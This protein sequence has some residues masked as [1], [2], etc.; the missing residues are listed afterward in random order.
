[1]LNI[2]R[3]K[4]PLGGGGR[5]PKIGRDTF[6][7]LGIYYPSK[8]TAEE[9]LK[10]KTKVHPASYG[11]YM[12]QAMLD[13]IDIGSIIISSNDGKPH[14]QIETDEKGL[15]REVAPPD[16]TGLPILM[17][18]C[19]Q[20]NNY[21][22]GWLTS[23]EPEGVK[24]AF[25]IME[26]RK[27]SL[28]FS[29]DVSVQTDPKTGESKISITPKHIAVLGQE[30]MPPGREG[31]DI[32][33]IVPVFP[34]HNRHMNRVRALVAQAQTQNSYPGSVDP[35]GNIVGGQHHI[36]NNSKNTQRIMT[37]LNQ[38]INMNMGGNP[39]G[40]NQH[41]ANQQQQQQPQ[42]QAASQPP[43][44][45]YGFTVSASQDLFNNLVGMIP[46][47]VSA[48]N[49]DSASCQPTMAPDSSSSSGGDVPANQ[50]ESSSSSSPPSPPEVAT[51][52]PQKPSEAAEIMELTY[53]KMMESSSIVEGSP[54]GLVDAVQEALTGL[55][56]KEL[57]ANPEVMAAL[58]KRHQKHKTASPGTQPEPGPEQEVAEKIDPISNPEEFTIATLGGL[59]N[60]N[61]SDNLPPQLQGIDIQT[62]L[63]FE[64]WDR[65][66]AESKASEAALPPPFD[67]TPPIGFR[68]TSGQSLS[69]GT[70]TGTET[71][72]EVVAPQKE[73]PKTN[74]GYQIPA[75]TN[76]HPPLSSPTIHNL[77][78]PSVD[79]PFVFNLPLLR[80]TPAVT[81]PTTATNTNTNNNSQELED[82][83][84]S[85]PP[86]AGPIPTGGPVAA[87]PPAAAAN[88]PQQ[89]A[90]PPASAPQQQQPPAQGQQAP[91]TGGQQQQQPPTPDAPL[92]SSQLTE[93]FKNDPNLTVDQQVS[94]AYQIEEAMKRETQM[95]EIT[96]LAESINW[97]ELRK[98]EDG[99]KLSNWFRVLIQGQEARAIEVE[100]L[101]NVVSQKDQELKNS[102]IESGLKESLT[103]LTELDG[104]FGFKLPDGALDKLKKGLADKNVS[105]ATDAINMVVAAQAA[106][107]RNMEEY[108]RNLNSGEMGQQSG[109]KRPADDWSFAPLVSTNDFNSKRQTTFATAPMSSNN[110]AANPFATALSDQVKNSHFLNSNQNRPAFNPMQQ[111]QQQQQQQRLPE[112]S[113]FPGQVSSSV[114]SHPPPSSMGYYGG[115]QSNVP[116]MPQQQY[117]YPMNPPVQQQ[118][119]QMPQYGA[120]P[121]PTQYGAA[122]SPYP[123]YQQQ[124]P[125]QQQQQS[126]E[127][128]PHYW[129]NQLNGGARTT[130]SSMQSNLDQYNSM[131]N[132]VPS[133]AT[134]IDPNAMDQ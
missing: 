124:Q 27:T 39:M 82:T 7:V 59:R 20:T 34:Q 95:P 40:V 41:T 93:R 21:L 99:Q 86:S 78:S 18:K 85:A 104:K 43:Y 14:G 120:A 122:P 97:G 113:I 22:V 89:Q 38:W 125:Q 74:S 77:Q 6:F 119:Q 62:L 108:V 102:H 90:P 112:N 69:T 60:H 33:M 106:T 24:C 121:A 70:G 117:Q 36:Y 98:S 65:R 126:P 91:A 67:L 28:S 96:K 110:P 71:R 9:A 133:G 53:K 127:S 55:V 49:A 42:Q 76:Q 11:V 81:H 50:A 87:P 8:Y 48:Y 116:T 31:S 128:D 114:L 66:M 3:G 63:P 83:E 58:Q 80:S 84:M 25:D 132:K 61:P 94:L 134:V 107:F 35:N 92:S 130:F 101:K 100:H 64:A 2:N 118:Q 44:D 47:Q 109:Q 23:D 88:I 32:L 123:Q 37:A 1:M 10:G 51:T 26:G 56:M 13:Q 54:I 131:M 17:S 68:S 45:A 115:Y 75:A 15:P 72:T 129:H 111:Q 79:Q 29:N 46:A 12:K 52:T 5:K 30:G 105:E 57:S 4:Q 19:Q 73:I 103:R 16:A